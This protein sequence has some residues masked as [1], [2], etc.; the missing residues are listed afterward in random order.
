MKVWRIVRTLVTASMVLGISLAA[1]SCAQKQ[2][3]ITEERP[4]VEETKAVP[5]Q[6]A[7]EPQP[8]PAPEV[9][10][11]PAPEEMQAP[12]GPEEKA[13]KGKHIQRSKRQKRHTTA[14][15]SSKGKA[16]RMDITR[17]VCAS[18]S[19]NTF[20]KIVKTAQMGATLQKKG[21]YTLFAP[22]DKALSKLS[23]ST[24][25]DLT[26][27]PARAKRFVNGHI[28]SGK[29]MTDKLKKGKSRTTISG[30]TLAVS[31]EKGRIHVGQ[32]R[33]I[34]GDLVCTNGVI[35]SIDTVL[36]TG[37]SGKAA[38]QQPSNTKRNA[39]SKKKKS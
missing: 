37:K 12:A 32:A 31:M 10:A 9:Q 34:H 7:P 1:S 28:V 21:P 22:T 4:M 39:N 5:A 26:A 29:I 3:P 30:R 38:H 18:P 20:A 24:L 14:G 17:T 2:K 27:S 8:Q 23:P 16:G 13:I 36:T 25:K 6:P 35:H 33:I 15:K 19:F 11:Q